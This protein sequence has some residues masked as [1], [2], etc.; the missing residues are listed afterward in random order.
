MSGAISPRRSLILS[1]TTGRAQRPA[2]RGP[3]KNPQTA[4]SVPIP[5]GYSEE[6]AARFDAL[7][8]VNYRREGK[9]FTDA[10]A[11]HGGA[12]AYG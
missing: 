4:L 6:R 10:A 9:T 5:V 3:G 8:A 7:L 1:T 12:T 11:D 2:F